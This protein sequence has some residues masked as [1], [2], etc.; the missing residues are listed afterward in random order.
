MILPIVKYPA[1]ILKEKAD[2][3]SFPLDAPTKKLVKDMFETVVAAKGIGLAA[4]QVGKSLRMIILDLSHQGVQ[5]FA[6]IN[7]EIIKFSKKETLL[8]EGCLSIPGVYGMVPRPQKITFTGFTVEGQQVTGQADGLLSK[9]IQHEVDH[10]NGILIID[11]ITKYTQ[12]EGAV[13]DTDR[14]SEK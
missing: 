6:L 11:K 2:K 8:E 9:A 12:K 7:P 13:K 3:V 5:P 1:K 10:T 14:F 4:P